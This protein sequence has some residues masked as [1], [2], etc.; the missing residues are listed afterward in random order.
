MKP[1][2]FLQQVF[3]AYQDADS[4]LEQIARIQALATRVTTITKAVPIGNG[5]A[6]SSRVENAIVAMEGQT[7]KLA[8]EITN[9]LKV[10]NEVAAEIAKLQHPAERRIL[11]Y[12]YLCF[13]SWK[14]IAAVMKT[15]L[16]YV[17][18]LHER[19]L[20]NF[21]AQFIKGHKRAY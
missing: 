8:D 17:F 11:E 19:A 2:E 21:S 13:H 14:E 18:K 1:K 9:L 6:L 16:R 3:I 20:E 15:G 5:S 10:R 12:R 4:K 7:E